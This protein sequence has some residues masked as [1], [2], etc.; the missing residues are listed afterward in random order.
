MNEMH[1][2]RS[3]IPVKKLIRQCC[4]EGFNSGIIGLNIFYVIIIECP[5]GAKIIT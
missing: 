4:V 2:S 3:K 5:V 1:G